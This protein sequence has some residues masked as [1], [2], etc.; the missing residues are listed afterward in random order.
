MQPPTKPLLHATTMIRI[1][2]LDTSTQFEEGSPKLFHEELHFQ[3][4]QEHVQPLPP[5]LMPRLDV[6]IKPRIP[7]QTPHSTSI[8]APVTSSD[9]PVGGVV[10]PLDD[11]RYLAA[12]IDILC[13]SVNAPRLFSSHD[14]AE[15]YCTLS[16]KA[17]HGITTTKDV[18]RVDRIFAALEHVKAQASTMCAAIQRDIRLAF[19]DPFLE[20]QPQD[21]SSAAPGSLPPPNILSGTSFVERKLTVREEKRGKDC[22]LVCI[23]ALQFLSIVF[24]AGP[25]QKIFSCAFISALLVVGPIT[26]PTPFS[27]AEQ[28]LLLLADTLKITFAP[29]LPSLSAYKI[30]FICFWT[31]QSQFLPR[32]VLAPKAS[33]ILRSLMKC[34]EKSSD[35]NFKIECLKVSIESRV[36]ISEFSQG[37]YIRSLR[38]FSISTQSISF[39]RLRI[40]SPQFCNTSSTTARRTSGISPP[41][42]FAL[43]P[44]ARSVATSHPP[45]AGPSRRRS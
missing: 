35:P 1:P 24:H 13:D 33:E 3:S 26:Y 18:S 44:R 2:Q 9:G 22:S 37:L 34:M 38:S 7:P 32:E 41:R 14:I 12:P 42:F 30:R 5:F 21:N 40:F 25:F 39:R 36:H 31:L 17:R 20:V 16:T 10:D 19:L 45:S 15:A 28:L 23:R 29:R 8:R 27:T 11:P 43:W 4:H 6:K